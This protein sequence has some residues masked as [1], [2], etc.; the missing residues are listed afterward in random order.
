MSPIRPGYLTSEWGLQLAAVVLA[1]F[2]AS[3][4]T[5]ATSA[6]VRI[7]TIVASILASLGY[8]ATRGWLK[9]TALKVEAIK[10]TPQI[11]S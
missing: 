10:G 4:L 8:T 1:A 5:P 6:A 3:D 9:A 7:A 2:L 11:P